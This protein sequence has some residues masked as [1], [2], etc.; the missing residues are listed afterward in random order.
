MGNFLIGSY[1]ARLDKSGR[2]K[3]PEKFR[4]AIEEEYG[5]DVVITSLE[6]EA[7]QVYPLP[8]WQN[9]T[10]IT[11]E[12][13]LPLKPAVKKFHLRMNRFGN[14]YEIDSK[15]RVLI[16]PVLRERAKLNEEVEVIGLSNYLE[17]WDKDILDKKLEERPLT[18][19]DF[20]IISELKPKGKPE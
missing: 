12:G 14:H 5:K 1:R 13:T 15:G 3:I 20:E 18:D 7:I 4:L 6:G 19:E 9:I 16:S 8:V 11:T 2:L 10:D 17:I